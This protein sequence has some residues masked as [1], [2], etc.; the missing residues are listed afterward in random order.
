MNSQP[1]IIAVSFDPT[2]DEVKIKRKKEKKREREK[3]LQLTCVL[4]FSQHKWRQMLLWNY[5]EPPLIRANW[6]QITLLPDDQL[7]GNS[8][9]IAM[10]E[11]NEIISNF[12]RTHQS[13]EMG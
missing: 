9:R 10:V 1:A 13:V 6:T 3:V 11:M 8:L 5:F 7:V 2:F 4:V 12:F